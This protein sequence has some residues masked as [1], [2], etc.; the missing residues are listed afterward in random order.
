MV[1]AGQRLRVGVDAATWANDRGFGRFT[2]ELMKALIA[3]DERIEYT[4][5]FD[6]PPQEAMPVGAKVL[7]AAT[8]RALNESHE[9]DSSRSMLDLLRM[10][11]AVRKAN[12]DVFFFPAVYSYF[13]ILGRMPCV[14]CYHDCTA[15]RLPQYLFPKPINHRL[16]QLKTALALRQTTRAMT[17][18]E[19]SANDIERIL[20]VPRSHIDVV[21]EGADPA[22][23]VHPQIVGIE[24][25]AEFGVKD[26][27]DLLVTLGGM[28]AHKNILGLLHAMPQ[29]LA[30]RPQVRLI[31]VGDT[32]GRGFWDNVPELMAYVAA[33]PPLEQHVQFSGYLDDD[34]VVRLLNG[35]TALVFP[36]LWEGFGLP[37]VEAMQCGV[38]VLASN[39]GSLPEVVGDAGLFF[40]PED[41]TDIA[42]TVLMFLEDQSLRVRL[43]K[44]ALTRAADFS[45]ERAAALAE[46]SFRNAA[47]PRHAAAS[48]KAATDPP[49][50]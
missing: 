20:K 6:R 47:S 35:A 16:W 50:Q 33:H 43:G 21:T 5:V 23:R 28:N 45:W 36:S 34:A 31:I 27:E 3:R 2:R 7:S 14:V 40:E 25:R 8:R 1:T 18:T 10:A 32:S 15:E 11:W 42:R 38:P 48:A 17:V 49:P 30:K 26:G 12:F 13:P 4:F 29:I 24:A 46:A 39:R 44:T 37:A 41:P 9:G 22:F 19:T